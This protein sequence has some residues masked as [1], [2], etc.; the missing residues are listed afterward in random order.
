MGVAVQ[1]VSMHRPPRIEKPAGP[2]PPRQRDRH[3]RGRACLDAPKRAGSD[4]GAVGMLR[5]LGDGQLV[6]YLGHALDTGGGRAGSFAL[7]FAGNFTAQQY[8]A[9]LGVDHDR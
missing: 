5:L 2:A 3:V 1:G 9:V 4:A 7:L 8:D 6:H